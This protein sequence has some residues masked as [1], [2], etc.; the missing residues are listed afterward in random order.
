[1]IN[2]VKIVELNNP[3]ITVTAK[4]L[5]KLAESLF[6]KAKGAKPKTVESVVIKIGR[7]LSVEALRTALIFVIPRFERKK[8]VWSI[9]IMALFTTIPDNI[10]IPNK[11][12]WLNV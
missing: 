10:N 5:H 2:K 11:T 12:D 3:P 1:M 9:K 6:P 7:N 4:G 8:F